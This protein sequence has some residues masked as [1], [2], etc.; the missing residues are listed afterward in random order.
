MEPLSFD[1]LSPDVILEVVETH[2][3]VF[4]DGVIHPYNSYINRVFGLTDE[5]GNRIIVKFYRPGRWSEAAI[6]DEHL[7]LFDCRDA[8]IPVVAPLEGIRGDTLG[9]AAGVYFAVYPLCRARSFECNNGDD[10]LRIGRVI[11]RMHALSRKRSAPQRLVLNPETTTASY[12]SSLLSLQ[13]VHPDCLD[14]FRTVCDEALTHIRDL[15][16]SVDSIRIHGDCHFGNILQTADGVVTLI[17]FDDMMTGPAVQDL[18]LLL[19]DRLPQAS[20][21][22]NLLLEGYEQ[23]NSFDRR[24]LDLIEPLRFMRHIYFLNWVA[25]QHVDTGFSERYP[26]WGSRSFWIREVEDL[27]QQ[28]RFLLR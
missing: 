25:S 2:T 20:A 10:Y 3:G 18:W 1:Q 27:N 6:R 28:L 24:T 11:G 22:L 16:D 26:G 17:D 14:D 15:F 23:F 8:E 5:D 21:E 12:I 13:L 9:N 4:L 19:P 7:F